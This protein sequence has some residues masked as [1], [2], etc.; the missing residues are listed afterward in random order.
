LYRRRKKGFKKELMQ[1]AK[2]RWGT[3]PPGDHRKKTEISKREELNRANEK[4]KK[5][6]KLHLSMRGF[7]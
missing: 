6:G 7:R 5:E 3:P 1:P 4:Q 2:I